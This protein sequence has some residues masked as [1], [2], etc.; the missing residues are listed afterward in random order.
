[1]FFVFLFLNY[2]QAQI[3]TANWYLLSPGNKWFY[4]EGTSEHNYY[5]IEVVGDT[6]MPN[7]KTYSIL[8]NGYGGRYQR[9]YENK[10]VFVYNK[11]DTS[12]FV[13]FDFI[14]A[15]IDLYQACMPPSIK[16]F[17]PLI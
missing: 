17:S 15:G 11:S 10:Y 3:D 6:L 1:M 5:S 16:I 7:G 13:L 4:E 2:I 14:L 12:E 9:N 8:K